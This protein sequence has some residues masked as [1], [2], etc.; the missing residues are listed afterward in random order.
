MVSA[1][2]WLPELAPEPPPTYALPLPPPIDRRDQPLEPEVIPVPLTDQEWF[3]RMHPGQTYIKPGSGPVG[4]VPIPTTSSSFPSP[5]SIFPVEDDDVGWIEDGYDWIDENVFD[6]GL[7]GGTPPGGG[8]PPTFFP[9]SPADPGG[10]NGGLPPVVINNGACGPDDPMRGYVY[11][12]VCGQYRWVKQK[13]R[14]RKSLVTKSDLNGLAS[15]KGILGT[16]KA[17]EVWIATH[18]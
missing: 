13:R 9:V 4:V 8:P 6:G 3:A 10:G 2:P 14:R 17:F 7:P 11:K 1:S 15:L 12:K 18:S 16:G 5:V